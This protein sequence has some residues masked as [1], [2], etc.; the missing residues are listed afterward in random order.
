MNFVG[1]QTITETNFIEIKYSCKRHSIINNSCHL[2][3]KL[4][5]LLDHISWLFC[6][7]CLNSGYLTHW[8]RDKMA[9]N[10][11]TT[12][13]NALTHWSQVTHVY[14]SNLTIFGSVNG[15][16]S[17][18]RQAIIW[19]IDEILLIGPIKITWTSMKFFLSKLRHFHSRKC[20]SIILPGKWRPFYLSLNEFKWMKVCLFLQVSLK[21]IAK[22]PINNRPGSV[23]IMAWHRTGNKPSS[24][25]MIA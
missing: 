21:C 6:I 13:S 20:Q 3:H 4:L 16:L 24:K 11:Q 18:R 25:P 15:L 1:C 17:S 22:G 7:H 2:M 23:H 10:L 19:T 14:V 12:F 5:R 8:G 9:A